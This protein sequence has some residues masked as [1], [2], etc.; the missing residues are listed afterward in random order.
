M[1]VEYLFNVRDSKTLQ[2]R[3]PADW[4]RVPVD[5]IIDEATFERVRQR[6]ESRAPASTPPRR[7]SS[8]TLLTG[9]L[10]CGH[11]GGAMTLTTGKSGKYRY[12]KCTTRV[13]KGGTFCHSRNLPMESVDNLV[14]QELAEHAFTPSRLALLLREARRQLQDHKTRDER[15]LVRLQADLR[16]AEERLGRLYDTIER[17]IVSLDDTFERRIAT[18]R[19]AREAILV[20]MAGLRRIQALPIER[21]LPS[22]VSVFSRVIRAKLQDRSSPFAKDYLHTLVDRITVYEGTA[23]IRGSNAKL[24]QMAGG[25]RKGTDQVPSFMRD[26]RAREDSNL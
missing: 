1:P 10:R 8:P 22:Q 5:P 24:L 25:T 14:L 9:L 16:K 4:I 3:A 11:C 18:A 2:R 7:V 13:N 12:Y 17:G 19:S 15:D 6:R 23:T 26:W 20:E 21:V